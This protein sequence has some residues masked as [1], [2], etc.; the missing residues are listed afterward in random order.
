METSVNTLNVFLYYKNDSK[1][2][3]EE[4]TN[5]GMWR[6]DVSYESK[7]LSRIVVS[8]DWFTAKLPEAAQAK[9]IDKSCF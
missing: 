9:Q 2:G 4:D 5:W 1:V 7:I 3:K 8:L 6:S